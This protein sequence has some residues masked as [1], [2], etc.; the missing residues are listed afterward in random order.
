MAWTSPRTWTTGES[1][2][3]AVLNQHIRDNLTYLIRPSQINVI[4]DNINTGS[5]RLA[6]FG[7]NTTG[8]P[9]DGIG[10]YIEFRAETTT[11]PDQLNSYIEWKWATATHASRASTLDFWLRDYNSGRKCLSL[12]ASG[13]AAQIGFLGASPVARPSVTGSK[14][15]NAALTSLCTA[16]AELGLI[17]NSTT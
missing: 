8:T 5:W 13:T 6:E 4:A 12:A 11:A 15:G 17:T 16:L 3:S 1:V 2:T 14:A 9:V 7:H 10:G